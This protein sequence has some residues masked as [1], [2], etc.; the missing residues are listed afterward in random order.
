[1]Y[2]VHY[3][4]EFAHIIKFILSLSD[5]YSSSQINFAHSFYT[6]TAEIHISEAFVKA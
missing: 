3:K 1:M 6:A 5:H 2:Q 4:A